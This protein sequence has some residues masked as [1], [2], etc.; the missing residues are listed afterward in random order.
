[1]DQGGDPSLNDGFRTDSI[2]RLDGLSYGDLSSFNGN[3][4][5]L[6]EVV[7]K[8]SD[9][10]NDLLVTPGAPVTIDGGTRSDPQ[11]ATD[12]DVIILDS[13]AG[14]EGALQAVIVPPADP[15]AQGA[16]ESIQIGV[17]TGALTG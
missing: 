8:G 11:G 5:Q 16:F 6:P 3:N 7:F 12:D 9:D 10:T 13:L 15:N 4:I 2:A 17:N 1:M 14:T